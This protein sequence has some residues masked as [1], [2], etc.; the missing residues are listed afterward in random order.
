MQKK[1][2]LLFITAILMS[3]TA[4]PPATQTKPTDKFVGSWASDSGDWFSLTSA[5]VF[6]CYNN[7]DETTDWAPVPNDVAYK[8]TVQSYDVSGDIVFIN[9]KV[10]D[11]SRSPWG[12]AV[13][14]Y[15]RVA[16]KS[17]SNTQ[18]K[19]AIGTLGENYNHTS[20]TLQ[21]LKNSFTIE[22][23]AFGSFGDYTKK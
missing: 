21:E 20:P 16:L 7:G 1:F 9:L 18:C 6:T 14:E 13:G 10:A 11:P 15:A 3:L 4:C 22:N 19:M 2:Y 17:V 23:G 12:L 8:G 5:G